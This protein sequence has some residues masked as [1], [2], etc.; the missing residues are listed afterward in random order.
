[1]RSSSIFFT[2]FLESL[3][4]LAVCIAVGFICRKCRVLDDKLISGLT[5]LLVKVTLPCTV[6]ISLMRPFSQTLLW[7][8]GATFLLSAA[9]FLFGGLAGYVVFKLYKRKKTDAYANVMIFALIFANVGY[10]GFPV[11]QA[12]FGGEGMIYASMVNASFNLLVWS[13]GIQMFRKHSAAAEDE[14]KF[15]MGKL[16]LS[17]IALLATGT[18]FVFF[19]TGLRLPQAVS[20][21]ISMIAGMTTPVS[22]LL[23]GAILAKSALRELF[24][25]WRVFPVI[26]ARLLILPLLAY[27]VLRLFIH[28]PVMLG[29]IVILTAMPAASLTAIF[30]EQYKSETALATKLVALSTLLSVVTV[31]F[32]AVILGII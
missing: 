22:M 23:V 17:N 26:A 4:S 9:V 7:E 18:G 30:A 29:V 27:A 21:G 16:I 32:V 24:R 25:D 3:V 15:S 8:S 5:T 28:N 20:G 1:M 2:A 14:Q 6:F 19:V 10:M 12:V 11:T 31:P 13:L